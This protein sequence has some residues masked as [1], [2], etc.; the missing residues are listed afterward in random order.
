MS[1]VTYKLASEK[2]KETQHI[3]DISVGKKIPLGKYLFQRVL[4]AGTKSIF[5]V[6]GD[7]NLPLL[8]HLYERDLV[9]QGLRWIGTCNELNAAYA[10]DGFSRYSNKIGCLITTYGVGELSALNGVAGAFA[11]NVKMLHIVGVAKSSAKHENKNIHHLIPNLHDS[12]FKRPNHK[13]YYEMVKDRVC[14]SAE[15]LEN[16][17]QACD[18][19]DKVIRDIYRY[20]KPGYIFIPVDFVNELVETTNLLV[21]PVIDLESSLARPDEVTVIEVAQMIADWIYQSGNPGLVGDV[22]TDRYDA[23]KML[24][25]FI[26]LT[27]MWN[28]TTVN[29]KSII[30]ESNPWYMGLYNGDEGVSTVIDRFHKCDLVLNFGL[31]INEINHGH[32]TFKYKPN[33]KIV[34]LHPTYVRFLDTEYG[35]ERLF[36]GLNFVFVLKELINRIN[37]KECMFSY[38]LSVRKFCSEEIKTPEDGNDDAEASTITQNKLSKMIPDYLNPGDI[39]V[40]ETGSFQFAMRDIVLPPQV[41]YMSQGFFLSIGTA[42]PAA[43]GVGIALQDYPNQHINNFGAVDHNYKPRLILLEGDGAAQMTVQEL[44]SMIRFQIPIEIMLWN[45]NGYTVERA[46][47]GPTR[48]YNDIMP[49]DWT[50]LFAAFG[51]FEGKYTRSTAIE[52][53]SKL[54]LKLNQLKNE[55]NRDI[56][57]MVEVKLGVMDYPHQLKHM[58]EAAKVRQVRQ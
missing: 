14:C 52:T 25:D 9:E 13:V 41:K 17:D 40:C 54:L 50:K 38:D 36:K 46:I 30:D 37:P 31:D 33:S 19:I 15:Y 21:T 26:Q 27:K 10:A 24:N 44:T 18:Q 55:G 35:T 3:S 34:E 6:P 8:E 22:L 39:V 43:V 1:P 5:G 11:E 49:W 47:L 32:Y 2:T 16:I 56:I 12:N 7:F 42:L 57:E 29:G 48:S 53:T 28:F 23:T 45:N 20:S 51:D 58:V 4:S